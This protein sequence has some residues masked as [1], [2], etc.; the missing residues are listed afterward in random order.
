[1]VHETRLNSKADMPSAY[2]DLDDGQKAVLRKWI[3]ENLQPIKT[4]SKGSNSY[5]LKHFFE[6]SQEGFYISNGM[7]KGAMLEA[8]YYTNNESALN[9]NF[10]V[11][12]KSVRALFKQPR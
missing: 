8:G 9:W 11:S 1:M 7:F 6:K 12:K 5:R 4:V 3:Y 2:E 10:N